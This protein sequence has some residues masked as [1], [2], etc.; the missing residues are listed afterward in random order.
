MHSDAA[1]HFVECEEATPYAKLDEAI[2][3]RG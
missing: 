3:G 2:G 1:V